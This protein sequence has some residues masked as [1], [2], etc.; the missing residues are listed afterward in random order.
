MAPEV[1]GL[2]AAGIHYNLKG[3]GRMFVGNAPPIALVPHTMVITPPGQPFR[4]DVSTGDEGAPALNAVEAYRSPAT[5]R[6]K[7]DT[8]V[9]GEGNRRSP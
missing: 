7:V 3:Q 4:I 9:A 8:F 5:S 6:G 2:W 1:S